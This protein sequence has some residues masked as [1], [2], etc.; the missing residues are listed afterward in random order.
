MPNYPNP[1]NPETKIIFS[2][3]YRNTAAL[4]VYDLLGREV[5]TLFSDEADGGTTRET[6]FNG[7]GLVSGIYVV[8]LE[9]GGRSTAQKMI[10]SK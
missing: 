5:R 8:R 1:F 4:R 9:S 10:L 2:V 6:V 7:D 3:P